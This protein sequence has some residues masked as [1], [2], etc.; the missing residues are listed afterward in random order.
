[1]CVCEV[2]CVIRQKPQKR[3]QALGMVVET[4]IQ[5]LKRQ[6]HMGLCEF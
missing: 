3:S 4:L 2:Q 5:A 1:M 6:R